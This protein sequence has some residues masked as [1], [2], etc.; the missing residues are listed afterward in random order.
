MH[1][2]SFSRDYGSGELRRQW[3]MYQL[4]SWRADPPPSFKHISLCLL[5]TGN[6]RVDACSFYDLKK[7]WHKKK[8]HKQRNICLCHF[9]SSST[10]TLQ[11]CLLTVFTVLSAFST[12][13]CW[14]VADCKMRR[15][16]TQ[17]VLASFQKQHAWLCVWQ[18]QLALIH[19]C[20]AKS[21]TD[22]RLI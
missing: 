12:A 3:H 14:M 15:A 5:I 16:L 1:F 8:S 10:V 18:L 22:W 21:A 7:P 4:C 6:F 9:C 17:N 2:S 20:D 13:F 19:G 11:S